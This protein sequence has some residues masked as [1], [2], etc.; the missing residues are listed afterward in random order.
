[1]VRPTTR[2]VAI[3]NYTPESKKAERSTTSVDLLVVEAIWI[4]QR[5][6][7]D[8]STIAKIARSQAVIAK[9]AQIRRA[10]DAVSQRSLEDSGSVKALILG[11]WANELALVLDTLITH[12]ERDNWI[13]CACK[14]AIERRTARD[15]FCL[16]GTVR[17]G[18]V[19]VYMP[20][21]VLC[22][23]SEWELLFTSDSISKIKWS[24]DKARLGVQLSKKKLVSHH[25]PVHCVICRVYACV[26]INHFNARVS[27]HDHTAIVDCF[28][29]AQ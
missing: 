25:S 24:W 23:F 17:N 10:A 3:S 4:D 21:T 9:Y 20:P 29:A 15:V 7:V 22:C 28:V 12:A 6:E 27:R 11:P 13:A 14:M 2:T 18:N 26:H 16:D 8:R 5:S 19:T 1:M